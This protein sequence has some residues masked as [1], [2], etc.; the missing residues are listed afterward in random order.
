M[1]CILEKRVFCRKTSFLKKKLWSN[2]DFFCGAI[3]WRQK[4][5]H[6]K[7]LNLTTTFFKKW[8]F[9]AEK[10]VFIKCTSC[11]PRIAEKRGFYICIWGQNRD[12]LKRKFF[13]KKLW[14][15]SDFFCG[16][17]FG[18][19]KSLHKQ[20]SCVWKTRY[21]I[22]GKFPKKASQVCEHCCCTNW[23]FCIISFLGTFPRIS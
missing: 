20:Q 9:S 14:S 6:K 16:T 3:F 15:N 10:H 17:F 12:C 1:T 8:R 19:K 2:S 4:K 22:L 18:A 5:F 23:R 11:G 7:S 13:K 21:E